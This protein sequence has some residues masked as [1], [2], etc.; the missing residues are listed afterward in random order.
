MKL[1]HPDFKQID[2]GFKTSFTFDNEDEEDGFI[3]WLTYM[4]IDYL[5]SKIPVIDDGKITHQTCVVIDMPVK[6]D[7]EEI[8]PEALENSVNVEENTHPKK[9]KTKKSKENET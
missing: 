1:F 6:D 2:N 7:S 4:D 9:K 8:D 3:G 5:R